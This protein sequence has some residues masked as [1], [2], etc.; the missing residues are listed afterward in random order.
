MEYI[1]N[2]KGDGIMN[3]R[4]NNKLVRNL[5]LILAIII[6]SA[7]RLL[8]V[9]KCQLVGAAYFFSS[10]DF[11][12][13]FIMGG[14]YCILDVVAKHCKSHMDLDCFKNAKRVLIY[15][16]ILAF[17]YSAVIILA[18]LIFQDKICEGLLVGKNCKLTL[19]LLLPMFSFVCIS[20][21]F[22]GFFIG[23]RQAKQAYL[24]CAFGLLISFVFVL[25]CTSIYAKTGAKV[26]LLMNDEKILNA[27]VSAGAALGLS[28]GTGFSLVVDIVMFVLSSKRLIM[29]DETRRM[30]DVYDLSIQMISEMLFLGVAMFIPILSIFIGQTIIVRHASYGSIDLYNIGAFYGLFGSL[31]TFIVLFTYVYSFFDKRALAVAYLDNNRQELRSKVNNMIKLFFTYS[32]PGVLL[33][34]VLADVICDLAGVSSA[35]ATN[36]IRLGSFAVVFY[37]F[38]IMFMNVLVAINKTFVATVDGIIAIVL[39]TIFTLFLIS[40]FD[41]GVTGLV[42]SFYAFSIIYAILIY[43]SASSGLRCR[44]KLVNSL[45]GPLIVALIT[46]A[47]C[48]VLKLIFGL[49]APAIVI[50][51]VCIVV[52]LIVMF[53]AF[54]KLGIT[55]YHHVCKSPISF[56]LVPLGQIIGLF[57]RGK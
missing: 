12:L 31:M 43:M 5:G 3:S 29:I 30:V 48:L 32:L 57:K 11:I 14:G 51:I 42:I 7:V 18:I 38:G 19:I 49:F 52:S 8:I 26:A 55:D 10:F 41:L 16:G 17:L 21:A 25:I 13:L 54:I 47:V 27:Y 4:G 37:A 35:L 15:G 9:K 40:K 46:S 50:F 6:Y 24:G 33:I 53:V 2:S 22:K 28:I 34:I 36:I 56:V 1:D 23:S 20:A 44:L 39:D 45:V